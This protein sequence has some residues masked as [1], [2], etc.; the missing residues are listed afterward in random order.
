MSVHVATYGWNSLHDS[1][2]ASNAVIGHN[3]DTV[4]HI[5]GYSDHSTGC[6]G[7]ECEESWN[8]DCIVDNWSP[9]IV[10]WGLPLHCKHHI[11]STIL[12][13]SVGGSLSRRGKTYVGTKKNSNS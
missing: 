5:V 11:V 9:A 4:L 7:C 8:S 10:L 3:A 2:A 1:T 6:S 13:N 12:L